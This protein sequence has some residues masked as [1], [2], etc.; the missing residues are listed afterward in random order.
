MA[1][2]RPSDTWPELRY[3]DYR[4][5]LATLHLYTQIIGKLRLALTPP[6]AQWAHAA[7]GL[8]ADGLTTGPLWV[9]DGV[10]SAD[11]DLVHHEARFTRSDGRRTIIRLGQGPMADFFARVVAALDELGVDVTINPLPQEITAPI[12]FDQDH[13]HA[14][15]DPRQANLLWQTLIRVGS[16]FE[17]ARSGFWGKQSPVSFYWGGFDLALTRYSGRAI[18]K[19]PEGLPRVMTSALDAEMA[20]IGYHL[21]NEMMPRASFAAAGFPAP[22]GMACAPVRPAQATYVEQPRMGGMFL[23]TYDDVRSAA[24]PRTTLLDFCT[25]SFAAIAQLS[26]WDRAL[27]ERRPTAANQAA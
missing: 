17:Q 24:D 21:G 1:P 6:L 19:V 26:G 22:Q 15:Y 27:L 23:L 2:A 18:Q 25:S 14:A 11:L 4:D 13:T 16:V 20:H 12:A 8:S 7:L 3:G 10:M 5:T 9:G